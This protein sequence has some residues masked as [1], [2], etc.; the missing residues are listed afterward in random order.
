M[1]ETESFT[2]KF[3]SIQITLSS[4]PSSKQGFEKKE[5]WQVSRIEG[6]RSRP[7][8]RGWIKWQRSWRLV[9]GGT[10]LPNEL[11]SKCR[12]N[13]E[14][15]RKG[16]GGRHA[17][18]L[19]S[20]AVVSLFLSRWLA[21]A[22]TSQ[23]VPW[24]SGGWSIRQE[25]NDYS[26]TGLLYRYRV[27]NLCIQREGGRGRERERERGEIARE[28]SSWSKFGQLPSLSIPF[29]ERRIIPW[30]QFSLRIIRLQLGCP[31]QF[32]SR[33]TRFF[34]RDFK[35]MKILLSIGQMCYYIILS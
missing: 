2:L 4:T 25:R 26:S 11:I 10:Q 13:I 9:T 34:L 22:S 29:W 5:K 8:R 6:A 31:K 21:C 17:T 27:A 33:T 16:T 1:R 12:P 3:I 32:L 30:R 14:A 24:I 19:T 28:L 23:D 18:S 15:R 35:N 7:Q 20:R